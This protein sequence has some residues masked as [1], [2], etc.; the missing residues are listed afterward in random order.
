M[1]FIIQILARLFSTF[2]TKNPLVAAIVMLVLSVGIYA[3]E[4][5][6]V[7][8]LFAAPDWVVQALKSVSLFLLSVTGSQTY[9]YLE[10]K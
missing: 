5:G 2:K 3:T 4:Q 6:Q 9:Q 7:F 8:G 10:K 1:D